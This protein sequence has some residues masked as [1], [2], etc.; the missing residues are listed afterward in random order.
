MSR[1]AKKVALPIILAGVFAVIIFVAL[2]YEQLDLN[3]YIV[4]LLLAVYVFAFGFATGQSF[5]TPVE[6]LLKGAE[7]LSNGNLSSR[8]Y[9]ETKDELSELAQVFDKIAQQL[10][11]SRQEEEN[12]E[13]S[14]GVKV[15][16]RTKELEETINALEQK[17][18]N[19][20]IELERLVEKSGKLQ[21]DA[22]NKETE[23]A[24][25]K[26]ELENSKQKIVKRAKP[27]TKT[28]EI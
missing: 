18:K 15:Q 11:T 17:V 14:V 21:S 6:K 28:E 25:L 4:L 9:L 5:A 24:Q 10:Q 19:R 7:D 22:V 12:A 20:T 16:A 23:V 2:E 1:F 13:K 26:K 27:K 3:S 8:V